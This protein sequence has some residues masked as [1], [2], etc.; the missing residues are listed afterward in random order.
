[1]DRRGYPQGVCTGTETRD[2]DEE[3]GEGE[4]E[5]EGQKERKHK[6]EETGTRRT[7]G[8]RNITCGQRKRRDRGWGA[9]LGR[10]LVSRCH[11][12]AKQGLG[13]RAGAGEGQG[14]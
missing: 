9:Y 3:R 8:K 2:T 14:Q 7:E 6:A 13:F 5:R 12:P 10:E 1:M 4:V 11:A